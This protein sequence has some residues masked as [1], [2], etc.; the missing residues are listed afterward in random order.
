MS[1]QK[2]QNVAERSP[3]RPARPPARDS[4]LAGKARPSEIGAAGEVRGRQAGDVVD[5]EGVYGEVSGVG[6]GL[7]DV[8][9][10]RQKTCPIGAKPEAHHAG[11]GEELIKGHPDRGRAEG[12]S[13]EAG[14]VTA[15]SMA[16]SS[17]AAFA[18]VLR[19]GTA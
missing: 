11:A 12:G 1:P 15:S 10:V 7:L 4:V 5:L 18:R 13:G 8:V 14:A 16:L 17:R 6:R 9:V 3:S 2:S 19:V